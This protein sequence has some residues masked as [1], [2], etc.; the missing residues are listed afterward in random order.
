MATPVRDI[1]N[2]DVDMVVG[3]RAPEQLVMYLVG[4]QSSI[5][6]LLESFP[7]L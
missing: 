4:R 2:Q 5:F 7:R 6:T 3:V 1:S